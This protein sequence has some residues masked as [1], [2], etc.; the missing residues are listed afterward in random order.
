MTEFKNISYSVGGAFDFTQ[1]GQFLAI[2]EIR[3][4]P[5]KYSTYHQLTQT[6]LY[7]LWYCLVINTSPPFY[8]NQTNFVSKS[9]L[10]FGRDSI[11]ILLKHFK[12]TKI[13]LGFLQVPNIELEISFQF[14]F[15][16]F[17]DPNFEVKQ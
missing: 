3:A 13:L 12:I 8:T 15:I 10:E 14:S 5:R 9:L 16:Y 11:S 1:A 2:L 7:K 4:A 6:T 17:L